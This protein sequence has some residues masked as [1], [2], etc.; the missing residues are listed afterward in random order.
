MPGAP[1]N[2]RGRRWWPPFLA[3]LTAFVVAALGGA[4]NVATS[5][6]PARLAWAHDA[7]IMWCLAGGLLVLAV[8]LA[9]LGGPG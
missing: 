4:T 3:G 5:L 9:V 8:V 2:R 7:V 1:N 6:L